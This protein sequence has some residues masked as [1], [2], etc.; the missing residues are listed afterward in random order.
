MNRRDFLK[1]TALIAATTTASAVDK[2]V[3][4]SIPEEEEISKGKGLPLIASSPMLQNY[5]ETSMGVAF[6]VNRLANG[7]VDYSLSPDMSNSKRVM[8]GG[9]RVND[10][11]DEV[12][13]IRLTG[14]K[15]A[16]KYYYQIG[17]HE[18]HY[19][20]YRD[21]KVLGTETDP[22]IYSFT[23]AGK[24]AKAHLC[25]INDT[26]MRWEPLAYCLDK[27][28]ELNPSCVIWNGDANTN[29]DSVA[30]QKK[31]FLTPEIERKDYASNIPY[32]FTP[33][34]HDDR[35]K[36]NWHME[37]V[38]MFRQPEERSSRDWDLGRNF[39]V[40]MG[41]IA[42]IGLDTAE[43]K[44]DSNPVLMGMFNSHAYREAQKTWLADA[45]KQPEIASAPFL[46]AFCHIPLYDNRPEMNPGDILPADK[47][48][49]HKPSFAVWQRTC[50]QLWT[51][52]LEKAGCQLIIT[53]HTH[54]FRYDPPTKDRKWAHLVGGGPNMGRFSSKKATK[55]DLFPT[56]IEGKIENKLLKIT[57][58]N[59]FSKSVEAE[60]TYK[61]RK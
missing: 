32:M 54:I 34:N 1:S 56:V 50:A 5:A 8:C 21:K 51:P 46:V 17:A 24:K 4:I 53:A 10:V 61:P 43:D 31:I 38:F 23:T 20:H 30:E 33:G 14:L 35:G 48:D 60:Y 26:H 58:H 22:K 18:I 59:I 42:L 6:A 41:D 11:N 3:N 19:K 28:A 37:R 45:L 47:D 49:F 57:V 36:A 25:V 40:R 13:R 29:V 9:F 12:M 27:V 44:V 2:T 39:A 7:F 55:P 15:P 52:L 16:T